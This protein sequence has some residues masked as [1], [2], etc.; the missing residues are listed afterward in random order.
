MI[1]AARRLLV[2]DLRATAWTWALRPEHVEKVR[3]GA[4]SGWEV[5]AVSALTSSDG[6]GGAPPSAESLEAIRDAEVYVGYGITPA[7]FSAA[8]RLR[9]V[10]SG[11]AGVASLLFPEMRSS[12]V[13]VTNSAGIHAI[14]IAEHVVAGLLY[15]LR[16]LD[17]AREQQ[18]TAT[19]ARDAFVSEGTRVRELG[20]CKA[21]V[22]G[23][24]GIGSE[25]ART[26]SAFG[27]RVT[28]VRRRPEL[29]VPSG[30]SA[31]VGP[32]EWRPLLADTDLLIITAPATP[33]TRRMITA[34]E[35]D[36]LPRHAIVANVA[37]GSLLDEEALA[38]RLEQTRLRGAVLDVFE[39]EPLPPTSRLWKLSSVVLTPHVSPVTPDGFW[40][41]QLELLL[42]NWHRY[43]AGMPMRNVV[44]KSAGY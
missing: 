40:P 17:L 19:W 30:F 31:V 11:A 38:E 34:A 1:D 29:G 28:G 15:L 36:E 16:C 9:W 26:L 20:R 6:D 5:R 35:L 8:P 7:L 22:I 44:D 33:D 32:S 27:T 41:R 25:V 13:V 39:K 21:L 18:R 3:E 42:D 23:A 10:H 12:D 24:G 43:A 4:P 14:P 2:L 37:R